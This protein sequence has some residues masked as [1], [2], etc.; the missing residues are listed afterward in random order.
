MKHYHTNRSNKKIGISF[1]IILATLY[2]MAPTA[3]SQVTGLSDW[4]LF[5]DPGHSR[6]ENMGLFNYS[7]AEKVL[8]VGLY[9]REML[10]EQTDIGE[11]FMAR[12]NHQQQVGLTE[13]TQIANATG[14]DF[15]YSIHSDAGS[16]HVN[17]NLM[18]YGGWRENGQ[19]VEKTPEGGKLFGDI[20]NTVL[21]A[22]MRI[23]T[24][25]NYADRTFYQGFPD[26]HENRFPWLAVNRL[27][28]M[29]SL[30]SEAGFHTN[31]TQQQRNLNAEWRRLEAKAAFWTILDFHNLERPPVGIV[32]GYITDAQSGETLNGITVTIGDK[33]YTTDTFESLFNRYSNDPDELSN[34]FYYIDGLE[35]GS[36]VDVVFDSPNHFEKEVTITLRT[37][38]FTFLDVE[39]ES[40]E[41]PRIVDV[42][43]YSD[44]D[45]L[46][47]GDEIEITFSRLTDPDS[48]EGAVS[49]EP[50][51]DF[52]LT[53]KNGYTI[54]ISTDSLEYETPYTFTITD[55]VKDLE[56]DQPLDGNDDGEAGGN[57]VMDITTAE[58]DTDPPALVYS[59]PSPDEPSTE[60]RPV[61]R[62]VF[63]EPIDPSSLR[64]AAVTLRSEERGIPGTSQLYNF[65]RQSVIHFFPTE[66]LDKE[67]EYTVTIQSG[68]SDRFGNATEEH[69]FVFQTNGRE[70]LEKTVIDNF[71]DGSFTG[72]WAPQQSGSTIGIRTEETSRVAEN[73]VV[74]QSTGSTGS[75][76]LNYGWDTGAVSHLI[77]LYLAPGATKNI[78]FNDSWVLQAYVFGDGSGNQFRFVVRDGNNDLESS[79][80]YDVDWLG[81]KLVS[82]D[83]SN[84]PV[85][86]WVGGDGQLDGELYTDSFQLTWNG[87]MGSAEGKFFIDDYRIVKYEEV[88]SSAEDAIAG[89]PVKVALEQNFPNPFN[90]TTVIRYELP[91]PGEVTLQVYDMIGRNVAVLA[92]GRKD[93]GIHNVTWD[94]SGLSSGVYI[95][96]LETEGRVLTRK[97]TLVK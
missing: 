53:W 19:T 81:W 76:R 10:E 58:P 26:N 4:S 36:T 12:E 96:R 21:T 55:Q 68:L 32:A 46:F 94:A 7:E 45:N 23:G 24:R 79:R 25:G 67:S 52:D 1:S 62:L 92:D 51:A 6:T 83:L 97:M 72:W 84:D 30:L 20:I 18:L 34:G 89:L 57:F 9:L 59:W 42:S 50:P 38:D 13:R 3:S 2:L 22:A 80:W 78:R 39:L 74:N 14:A 61:I 17:L 16:P 5:I 63:D 88:P 71:N 27:T 75:M 87:N 56:N 70:I 85:L 37:R 47:P 90:P 28:N 29:A 35:P 65:D 40:N 11:I 69:S 8:E 43:S 44:F 82:W 33:T 66:D 64:R 15:Y 95:Y 73:N 49:F 77:R 60:L 93:A 41:A 31:P 54:V 48:F 91:V 86:P